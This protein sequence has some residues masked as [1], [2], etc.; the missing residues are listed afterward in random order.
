MTRIKKTRSLKRIHKVKTGSKSKLKKQLGT[1][2]Q[3]QK[4]MAGRR[5]LSAYEKFL[6]DNPEAQQ[7]AKAEQLAKQ[8]KAEREKE[9]A[10]KKAA[11]TQA[12]NTPPAKEAKPAGKSDVS[13]TLF[14]QLEKKNLNDLY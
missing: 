9:L 8:K 5:V 3:G 11:D 12:D 7:E 1:D 2:R 14:E 10:Q 13:K 6:L 4:R